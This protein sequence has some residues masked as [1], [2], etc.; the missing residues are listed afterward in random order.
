MVT[1]TRSY[2][3]G[4]EVMSQQP[5]HSDPIWN[6]SLLLGDL[7]QG[8][9]PCNADKAHISLCISECDTN[10]L[11]RKFWENEEIPQKLPFKEKDE[12]CEKYFI[13]ILARQKT[14]T[15]CDYLYRS[16]SRYQ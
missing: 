4:S 12:Q 2:A 11:L 5:I 16:S 8:I 3:G 9:A 7:R 13:S 1:L 14:D 10:S 6:E 15:Q